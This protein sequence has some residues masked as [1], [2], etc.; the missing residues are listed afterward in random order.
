M[1]SP[2]PGMDP[3]LEE[4]W[5]DIHTRMIAYICDQLEPELPEGLYPQVEER[6]I[7]D[8]LIGVHTSRYPDL[9]VM[10]QSEARHAG[11]GA[12]VATVT[13]SKPF[14]LR[15]EE[16]ETTEKFL[17]IRDV[18]GDELVTVVELLSA[19][20]KFSGKDRNNYLKKRAEMLQAGVSIVEID[21]LRRGRS[22]QPFESKSIP[23]D[24]RTCYQVYVRRGWIP[25][26]IEIHRVPLR[27][28]LP[29][30]GIPLRRTDSDAPL[31]LQPPL[32]RCYDRGR[33]RR[34][35]YTAD[36]DP[37]LSTDDAKWADELLR[38]KGLR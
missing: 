4:H 3:Y 35:D 18:R 38:Q 11:G 29:I 12:P 13:L 15:I 2:F 33:Y 17:E 7:V 5:R 21:L 22:V 32:D 1:P 24:F 16:E 34:L 36:P 37:P 9:R 28:R 31:D 23:E 27:E 20:N 30:V 6:V 26:D 14:V 10:E 8:N 19:S 25:N